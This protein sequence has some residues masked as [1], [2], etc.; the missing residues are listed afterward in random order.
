MTLAIG[1]MALG[2]IEGPVLFDTG[3]VFNMLVFVLALAACM[4]FV[5]GRALYYQGYEQGEMCI[6]DRPDYFPLRRTA[7][8]VKFGLTEPFFYAGTARI[9][10]SVEARAS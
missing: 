7:D 1:A 4:L 2:G 6:R 9:R 5:C 10:T 3:F 8:R